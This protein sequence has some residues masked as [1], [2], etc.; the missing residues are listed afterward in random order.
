MAWND[1]RTW[2][3]HH[4]G[5]D[6]TLLAK[7]LSGN[8][9]LANGSHQAGPYIPKGLLFRLLPQLNR[10]EELNPSVWLDIQVDS[11]HDTRRVRVVW[12]NNKLHG[13]TR[14]ETR[15]T[16]WGGSQS[17]LLDPEST[18][19]VC[20]FAFSISDAGVATACQVWLCSGLA[21]EDTVEDRIGPI[22]PGSCLV[23]PSRHDVP[24]SF[25]EERPTP[26]ESCRLSAEELPP[27]WLQEFPKP[28]EII[29]KTMELRPDSHLDADHRLIRRRECEL[30][31]FESVEE[32][33]VFPGARLVFE[34]MRE[35][36]ESAR[37]LRQRRMVRSGLSLEL[38]TR[39]IFCEEGLAENQDFVYNKRSEGNKRPDFL[40]PSTEAYRDTGFPTKNLRML[41]VKNTCKD[42]WRQILN[43]ADRIDRKHLLTLQEGVSEGQFR[44]MNA[45]QVQL[46]IP[47]PL[48][49]KFPRAVQPQLQTLESFIAEIQSIRH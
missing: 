22:E 11:H 29:E 33:L 7:R 27:Q 37:T 16:N 32:A 43:E 18:G 20:L 47:K 6:F 46:V 31:I 39:A 13:G 1:L 36:D 48:I 23:K 19:A 24:P 4:S 25:A 30:E 17:A 9:T 15:I 14:N 12:Y 45:A 3:E 2:L 5:P 26:R 44:E 41:A 28:R 49:A 38:H 10:P 21:E 42:R 35:F 40:F 8:D 34:S